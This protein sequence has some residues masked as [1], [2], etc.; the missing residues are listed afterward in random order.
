MPSLKM[1]RGPEPGRDIPLDGDVLLIGRGRKND[2]IIQD[3]EVSR[4]HCRLVRVLDDYEIHDLTSTN[5]TFVNGKEVNQGGWLLHAHSIVELGDSITLEYLPSDVATGTNPP[6]LG[7]SNVADD[8]PHYI[9]I[10]QASMPQPE[11]YLL[12]RSTLSMG[13]DVDN[14]IVLQE[15]EVSR[16]HMRLI[17]TENGYAV[18]DLNTMN[19]TWVNDRRLSEQRILR[20]NDMVRIGTRVKMWYTNDPDD[21]IEGLRD[22]TLEQKSSDGEDSDTFTATIAART[23]KLAT[24]EQTLPGLISVQGLV[25]DALSK[26]V[27]LAYAPAEW[28]LIVGKLYVYLE[29]NGVKIW[30]PQ[31]LQPETPDWHDAIAQAQQES[32]LLL[33]ILSKRSLNVSYVQ[34]SIRRFVTRDKPILLVQLGSL[35][36]E[37]MLTAGLS[38]IRFDTQEPMT[39]FRQILEELR[40]ANLG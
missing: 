11:I 22:G 15:P 39:T 16:H 8:T 17:F 20:I 13:R 26:S 10:K 24:D 35:P 32:P 23:S 30:T 21:L 18:E 40:K 4:T 34:R 38:R 7:T 12:D 5:G 9:I 25:P 31:H 1:L 3:N 28:K 2:I 27:F 37:P 29:D 14:E 36:Q 19:G 6:V 33:A